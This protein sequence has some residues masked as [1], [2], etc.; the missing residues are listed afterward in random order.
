[1]P[2]LT[3]AVPHELGEAEAAQRLRGYFAKLKN[4]YADQVS[5][6][7]DTWE[8]N[9]LKFAFSTYG[10]N[11]QGK[12]EVSDSSVKVDSTVPFAAMMF[13]GKIESSVRSELDRIL[14]P[15]PREPRDPSAVA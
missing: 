2:S 15:G 13:K 4:R 9:L 7:E 14:A 11:V 5:N 12:L 1:M 3:M 10:M 6:L 8:G